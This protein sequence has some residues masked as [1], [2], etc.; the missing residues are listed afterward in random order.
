MQG[1]LRQGY[2]P[3]QSAQFPSA[4]L[5]FKSTEATFQS[6]QI[7]LNCLPKLTHAGEHWIRLKLMAW[8]KDGDPED[9][10]PSAG[11]ARHSQAPFCKALGILGDGGYRAI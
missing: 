3:R 7:R 4:R 10:G 6:F 5:A 9:N 2:C 1:V 11:T 8:F